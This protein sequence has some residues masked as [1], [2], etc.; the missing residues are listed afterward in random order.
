MEMS[1]LQI[2]IEFCKRKGLPVPTTVAGATDDTTVQ[3]WG[4]LNEGIQDVCD[5][6]NFQQLQ[7][8]YTFVHAG[9]PSYLAFDF[10]VAGN[11]PGWKFMIQDTMW[12]LTDRIDLGDPLSMREWQRIVTM[13]SGG[14]KYCWTMY[15]NQLYI[16]PTPTNLAGTQFSFMWQSKFGVSDAGANFE[17]Y[18]TDASTPRLPSYLILADLKWRWGAAKGLPYAEDQRISESMLINAVGRSPAPEIVLDQETY[19]EIGPRPG[20]MVPAGSWNV[21]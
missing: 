3:I 19:E 16:F 9:G 17:V 21:S 11:L 20:I 2:G 10:S 13:Q 7:N 8:R 4:L 12:C 1:L 18:I 14:A 6:Y 15:N 5:R